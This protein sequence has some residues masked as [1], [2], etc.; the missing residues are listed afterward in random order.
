MDDR[1]KR[2]IKRMKHS[3]LKV[4]LLIVVLEILILCFRL[5]LVA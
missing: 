2:D 4:G 1:Q 3:K 5:L